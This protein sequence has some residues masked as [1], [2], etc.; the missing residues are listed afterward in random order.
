MLILAFCEWRHQAIRRCNAKI[1]RKLNARSSVKLGRLPKFSIC[2][3][4]VVYTTRHDRPSDDGQATYT[5][6][7]S[8]TR[9]QDPPRKS[10]IERE[11][12]NENDTHSNNHKL[13]ERQTQSFLLALLPSVP[14]V[15]YACSL[16]PHAHT[17]PTMC[18]F[19]SF[20]RW[21]LLKYK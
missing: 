4:C 16:P 7:Y 8:A 11:N 18:F 6:I 9:I 5:Q 15:S 13:L 2:E 3:L 19:L 12:E 21:L 14:C 20:S 17:L 10:K 1:E